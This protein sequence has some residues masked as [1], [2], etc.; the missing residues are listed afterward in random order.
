MVNYKK[1]VKPK[2]KP[3]D[4]IPLWAR[5]P[6]REIEV[7]ERALPPYGWRSRLVRTV[8]RRVGAHLA[9]G[10]RPSMEKMMTLANQA[11][12]ELFLPD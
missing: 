4:S 10:E 7:I 3:N 12:D 8:V 6:Y 5:V 11:V 1:P 2:K 9:P